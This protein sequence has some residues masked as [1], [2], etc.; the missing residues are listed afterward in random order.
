MARAAEIA[1]VRG[2]AAVSG[3]GVLRVRA[4]S[5]FI[6]GCVLSC[7]SAIRVTSRRAAG[8]LVTV[9][10]F[11]PECSTC[12]LSFDSSL[13]SV[14]A[15]QPSAPSLPTGWLYLCESVSQN[16]PYETPCICL[17]GAKSVGK[18]TLCRAL[19]NSLLT[20]ASCRRVALL[21]TDPGQQMLGTPGTISLRCFD[22]PI[23]SQPVL[24]EQSLFEPLAC[25]FIA[26]SSPKYDIDSFKSACARLVELYNQQLHPHGIPLVVNTMG[27]VKGIG[28]EC[29]CYLLR[30][31]RLTQV[32]E[33]L[34][35]DDHQSAFP[36]GAFWVDCNIDPASQLN[37]QTVRVEGV[38]CC[39]NSA[40]D[41][42]VLWQRWVQR[43]LAAMKEQGYWS[44]SSLAPCEPSTSACE[45]FAQ[46]LCRMPAYRVPLS[47]IRVRVMSNVYE[48]Q[49][50][51]DAVMTALAKPVGLLDVDD[52]CI[53][54]GVVRSVHMSRHRQKQQLKV[55]VL[56]PL[57]AKHMKRVNCLVVGQLELPQAFMKP[58]QGL[59][60][61]FVSHFGVQDS[62]TG[63]KVKRGRSDL[64]RS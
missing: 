43:T 60:S 23:V 49:S 14:E 44:A 11:F 39:K 18:S 3:D 13:L 26:S 55:N 46:A 9:E 16:A 8:P 17:C 35:A 52:A 62:G 12:S 48:P 59:D 57:V 31:L 51:R 54:V 1:E 15:K 24:S 58:G 34:R 50:S 56:A 6:C 32:V 42:G 45:G 19:A 25:E 40:E 20:R 64:I 2:S 36:N 61:P 22:S 21:D 53:G 5:A 28:F 47:K 30:L 37:I 63:A 38:S 4:G 10:P 29:L 27:W 7:G 33:L 41:R